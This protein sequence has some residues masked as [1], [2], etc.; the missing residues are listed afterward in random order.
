MQ[1]VETS[2]I[3]PKHAA[4]VQRFHERLL[5]ALRKRANVRAQAPIVAFDDSE[6]EPDI[7]VVPNGD[8]DEHPSQALLIIEVANASLRYDR[9]D[10]APLYAAS[11]FQEYWIVNLRDRVVEVHRHARGDV[12]T[13]VVHHP[14]E[15]TLSPLAFPD[16]MIELALLLRA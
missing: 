8:D 15:A 7:A 1:L 16:V 2:A 5:E 14:R 13:E 9:E 4:T 3:D 6:P 11:G 12:W 10:K